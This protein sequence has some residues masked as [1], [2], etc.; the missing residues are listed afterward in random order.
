MIN[1]TRENRQIA[2]HKS[3]RQWRIQMGGGARGHVPPSA[4]FLFFSFF[5][6]FLNSASVLTSKGGKE[7]TSGRFQVDLAASYLN[8]C[9]QRK[10]Q[11]IRFRLWEMTRKGRERVLFQV[12]GRS[13]TEYCCI[14]YI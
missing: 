2:K 13:R 9:S 4:F 11:S 3:G 1:L 12:S 6:F 14:E 5:I 8:C 10:L 7:L